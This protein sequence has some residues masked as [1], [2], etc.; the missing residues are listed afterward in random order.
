MTDICIRPTMSTSRNEA[1]EE[2]LFTLR[3]SD[4]Y[5][6]LE[7]KRI[8]KSEYKRWGI[9]QELKTSSRARDGKS[10]SCDSTRLSNPISQGHSTI[11]Y[12]N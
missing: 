11:R 7:Q 4:M 1:F 2:Q 6:V 8:I 12:Y 3:R 10:L 5:K 9:T